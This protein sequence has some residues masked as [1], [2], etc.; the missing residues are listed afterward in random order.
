MAVFPAPPKP[1]SDI[2]PEWLPSQNELIAFNSR[3]RPT[4]LAQVRQP[5]SF[6]EDI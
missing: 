4:K 5:L 1:S 2:V 6:F 3:P